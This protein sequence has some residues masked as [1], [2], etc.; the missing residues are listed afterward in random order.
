M[1]TLRRLCGVVLVMLGLVWG[2]GPAWAAP[3]DEAETSTTLDWRQLGMGS[4]VSFGAMNA[5]QTV[6]IPVPDGV[7]PTTL[8]GQ[9]QPAVNVVN[10][11]VEVQSGDGQVIG[12]IPVPAAG[13]AVRATPFTVDL[14]ATQVQGDTA[15]IRLVLRSA[16][17]D[18][19][20]GP[21]PQLS[22]TNLAVSFAGGQ[23][24]PATV[25]Q[26]FPVGT[27]ER[28]CVRGPGADRF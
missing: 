25:E 10:G 17:L 21:I 23:A 28:R 12:A 20:C 7:R 24:L 19:V 4:A 15:V 22:L 26:F 8:T 9:L 27:A 14:S 1:K 3:G 5:P 18:Q 16:D 11:Y 13:A 6:T 2:V